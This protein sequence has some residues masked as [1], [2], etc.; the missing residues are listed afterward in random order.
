VSELGVKALKAEHEEVLNV[1]RSLTAEEWELPSDCEGWRVQDVI[2]HMADVFRAAVDPGALPPGVP[3]D[4]EASQSARVD[5]RREWTSEK[6]LA[7]Y[8]D[9]GARAI[10]ALGGLQ[11]PGAGDAVIPLENL[12]SYPMHMIANA[13]A[14]DHFCHLRNDIL[15]PNGPIDRPAPPE[16]ET[17]VGA[18]LEWLIAGLPQM[19][20]DAMRNAVKE[21]IGLRLT[22]PG[23]GEWTISPA[24]GDGLVTVA[25]GLQASTIIASPGTEFVIWG[26][27]RRPWRDRDVTIEGDESYAASVLDA[28]HLF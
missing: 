27:L 24:E 26:T 18:T 10:E 15:K 7:E 8:E 21:P 23:G 17:R 28:I 16:D 3:G 6:V 20:P 1:A 9:L 12:G 22:G 14:F 4:I 19:A 13:F 5:A 2:V 11:A 25:E